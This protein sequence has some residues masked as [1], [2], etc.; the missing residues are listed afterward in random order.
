MKYGHLPTGFL[1]G[2]PK[3]IPDR[4]CTTGFQ[5]GASHGHEFTGD[6]TN[7][8]EKI[9][10]ATGSDKGFCFCDRT[11]NPLPPNVNSDGDEFTGRLG[12]AHD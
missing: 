5:E 7:T 8:I 9:T 3:E 6:A 2:D 12:S 4:G 11:L 10:G 1:Q